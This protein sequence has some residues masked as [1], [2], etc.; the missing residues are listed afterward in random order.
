MLFRTQLQQYYQSLIQMFLK[1][2]VKPSL[3]NKM[4]KLSADSYMEEMP[5]LSA[6]L[7]DRYVN[8]RSIGYPTSSAKEMKITSLTAITSSH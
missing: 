1:A 7:T 8:T 2:Y 5:E 3:I 6:S 4:L